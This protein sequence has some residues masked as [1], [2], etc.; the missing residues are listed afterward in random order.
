LRLSPRDRLRHFW[1]FYVGGAKA[2][3]GEWAQALAWLRTSIDA[4]RNYPSPFFYLAGCLAHLGRLD[5][6]RSEVKAGLALNPKFTLRRY[7]AGAE[8]DN[9][10]YLTQR[11]RIIE[12]MRMAD[13]PEE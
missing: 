9:A 7:L 10:V 8:S 6:A 12:G 13:V 5:E 3:L 4:N 1:L 11:E 2:N